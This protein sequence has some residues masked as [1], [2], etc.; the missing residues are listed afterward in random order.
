MKDDDNDANNESSF[1]RLRP[2]WPYSCEK[3][4]IWIKSNLGLL[5]EA[6]EDKKAFADLITKLRNDANLQG[7][8]KVNI[9]KD[10]CR[11]YWIEPRFMIGCF[12]DDFEGQIFEC[13]RMDF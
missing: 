4:E 7:R 3:S 9:Y 2:W 13:Q 1:R 10:I 6:K 5:G 12:G 11:Q 8:E